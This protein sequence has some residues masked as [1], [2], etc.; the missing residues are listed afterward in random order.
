MRT[1]QEMQTLKVESG[2]DCIWKKHIGYDLKFGFNLFVYADVKLSWMFR[3]TPHLGGDESPVSLARDGYCFDFI[4]KLLLIKVK[5]G[6]S[7][8]IFPEP[9]VS[10]SVDSE[11]NK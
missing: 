2:C 8:P 5:K 10:L 6:W 7:V 3:Q 1:K 9:K 11:R 4:T